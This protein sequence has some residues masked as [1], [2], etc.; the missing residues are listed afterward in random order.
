MVG[1]KKKEAVQKGKLLCETLRFS[2][3]I[4]V[5]TIDTKKI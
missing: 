5:I 4:S 2:M 1:A 3:K